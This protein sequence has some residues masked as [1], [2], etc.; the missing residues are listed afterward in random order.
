MEKKEKKQQR[1]KVLCVNFVKKL[2][3]DFNC[4]AYIRYAYI[5]T[6]TLFWMIDGFN[7]TKFAC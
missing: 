3:M 2:L 6:V 5:I 7:S 1:N 4:Y